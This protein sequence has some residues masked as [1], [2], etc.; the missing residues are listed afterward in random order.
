MVR[1]SVVALPIKVS[2]PA[3]R[4]NVPEAVADAASAVVP[5][6]EPLKFAPALPIVGV[7]NEGEVARTAEPV[8]VTAV[9]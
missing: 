5:D 2:V 6:V 8:P 3:G 9:I 7:V 4:V 1:V